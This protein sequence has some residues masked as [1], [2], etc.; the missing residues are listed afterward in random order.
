MPL[1]APTDS[2]FI[3]PESR[4]QPMHVGS[5]QL[6][7]LPAGA[8]RSLIRETYEAMVASTDV[9]PLFRMRPYRSVTTLGQW[10]WTHDDDIDLEHH[11]RHSALPEPGR[12][13]E[14]LA[15]VSRLHGTLLDRQR[16]MWEMH[17]IEG[18]GDDRFAV[19]TKLHH[20]VMDG[21]S[22]L[23]LLQRSLSPSPDERTSAFWSPRPR[24]ERP[25]KAGNGVLGLPLMAARGVADLAR[26]T[27]TVA[28]LANQ[29]L[30][31]HA[32]TLPMQAPKSMLN[33][34]ITGARR[35]AAQSWPLEQIRSVGKA[36]GA[37]V[38]D[39]VL[40]MC[41]GALRAYLLEM[42]A[43]PDAPLIAMTPV[44]L[45]REDTGEDSGNAV[46]TIL[47][48]LATDVADPADRLAA[49]HQSMQQGKALF[50]GLN[51]LQASAISAAMMAPLMLSMMPG[52]VARLAPPPFNLIISN[53]PG[54]QRPLYFNGARLAGI[55]P[56]SIPT[57][58]QALNITV[59]SYVDNMEFGLTGCRRSVPHLQ[60]LLNHL[61]DA[62]AD[63]VKVTGA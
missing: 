43:L 17:V 14:L 4:E 11:V 29:A 23:R 40:A 26:L 42:D 39:V 6:F 62:L 18:L 49:V 34:P 25:S 54:P 2:L 53:V 1:M 60:R 50:A 13:R 8:D 59:T 57:V 38:N 7:D 37:T 16:P 5:L 28:R 56:L 3:I 36:A 51:Q 35:F 44:S 10:A 33:V 61:D 20:S 27:P 58:G 63:L 48:N 41:S 22:G 52:G 24:K 30:R 9:A 19:Y 32:A 55:Y 47:A 31:E 45:R 12:I 46:G 15:L 21:V